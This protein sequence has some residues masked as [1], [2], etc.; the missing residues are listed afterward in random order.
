MDELAL[1]VKKPRGGIEENL[2]TDK[3][4]ADSNTSPFFVV[5]DSQKN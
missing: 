4:R 5:F 1:V 3:V 2:W